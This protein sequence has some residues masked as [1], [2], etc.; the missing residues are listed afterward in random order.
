[1]FTVLVNIYA[2][3]MGAP[4]YINQILMDIKGEIDSSTVKVGEFITVLTSMDRFS[5]QKIN[6]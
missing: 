2:P 1:M 5:R 3:N 4:K 6:K